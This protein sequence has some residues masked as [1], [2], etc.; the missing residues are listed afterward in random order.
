MRPWKEFTWID[1]SHVCLELFCFL[2]NH[3]SLYSPSI[4]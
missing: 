1:L 4:L 2:I 3:T